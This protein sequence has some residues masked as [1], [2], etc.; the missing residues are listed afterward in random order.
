MAMVSLLH[1]FYVPS[2]WRRHAPRSCEFLRNLV[3][4]GQGGPKIHLFLIGFLRVGSLSYS[5]QIGKI[6]FF[7]GAVELRGMCA[8][9]SL[10]FRRRH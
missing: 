9:I 4:G 8:A 1:G 7:R 2:F 5:I 10:L 6:T 3:G